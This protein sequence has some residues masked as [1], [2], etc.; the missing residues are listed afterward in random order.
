MLIVQESFNVVV[1]NSQ[2]LAGNPMKQVSMKVKATGKALLDWHKGVFHH[3]LTEI[4]LIRDKLDTLMQLPFDSS[5][6][7]QR[8]DLNKQTSG[9]LVSK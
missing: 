1:P 2:P 3:R 6:F 9:T 7:D 5:Q 8:K 4:N